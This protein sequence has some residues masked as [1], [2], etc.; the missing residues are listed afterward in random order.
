MR[1]LFIT[2]FLANVALTILAPLVL[3]ARVAIHFGIGGHPDSW[4]SSGSFALIFLALE[5]PLFLLFL[6]VPSLISKCP[7]NIVSLPNRDYWLSD[8]NKPRAMARLS[9]LMFE[10][11]FALFASLLGMGLLTIFANLEDPVRLNESLFLIIFIAFMAY[12]A[13]WCV[14]IFRAFK[15]PVT[16]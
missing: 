14:K 9:G 13:Y 8:E 3:P 11:G 10:F 1:K 4:A 15:I 7:P 2:I 16:G 12:T 5:V 6:F